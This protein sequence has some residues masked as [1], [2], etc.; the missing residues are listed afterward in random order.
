MKHYNA[1]QGLLTEGTASLPLD[2]LQHSFPKTWTAKSAEPLAQRGAKFESRVDGDF[3]LPI[4]SIST[5]LEA[6][7][8]GRALLVEWAAAQRVDWNISLGVKKKPA[9][10]EK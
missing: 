8:V 3:A 6:V 7:R 4:T 10:K 5:P 1:A 2:A 9:E